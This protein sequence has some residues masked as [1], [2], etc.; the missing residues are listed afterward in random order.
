MFPKNSLIKI[1][2]NSPLV[3][4]VLDPH[5]AYAKSRVVVKRNDQIFPWLL[6]AWQQ[7]AEQTSEATL[8]DLENADGV[9]DES[10]NTS[11]QF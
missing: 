10:V 3:C 5:M 8:E 7:Y 6:S 2:A 9:S 11:Q 1:N 4:T